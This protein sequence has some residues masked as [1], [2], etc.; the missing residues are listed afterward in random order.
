MVM[1]EAWACWHEEMH[2]QQ[3]REI[4]RERAARGATGG[5]RECGRF[6]RSVHTIPYEAVCWRS[7]RVRVACERLSRDQRR[8]ASVARR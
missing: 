2:H 4:E 8:R 6:E 7:R 1:V 5:M 3:G